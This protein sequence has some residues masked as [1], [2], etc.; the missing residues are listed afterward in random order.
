MAVALKISATASAR[1]LLAVELA[2]QD[3][4]RLRREQLCGSQELI[5]QDDFLVSQDFE[6]LAETPQLFVGIDAWDLS[7]HLR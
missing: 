6:Q 5:A 1:P 7:L 2:E 3:F 4:G